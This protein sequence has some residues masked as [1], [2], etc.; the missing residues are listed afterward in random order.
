MLLAVH[1]EEVQEGIAGDSAHPAARRGAGATAT[2]PFAAA[3]PATAAAAASPAAATPSP[4]W[5]T[6]HPVIVSTKIY[7]LQPEVQHKNRVPS[8][9]LVPHCQFGKRLAINNKRYYIHSFVSGFKF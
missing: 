4:S 5:T 6:R 9:R 1:A 7:A 3:T 8:S 2:P